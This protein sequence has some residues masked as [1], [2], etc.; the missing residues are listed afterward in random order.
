MRLGDLSS[1]DLGLSAPSYTSPPLGP[2]L[3]H[4]EGQ[5]GMSEQARFVSTWAEQSLRF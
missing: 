5:V 4:K 3:L 1:C 2:F